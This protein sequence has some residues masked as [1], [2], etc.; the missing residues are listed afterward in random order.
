MVAI[1]RAASPIWKL[2]LIMSTTLGAILFV[3][4]IALAVLGKTAQTSFMLFGNQFSST[5]VGVS[6][7]FLGAVFV[8]LV[9]RRVLGGLDRV[10]S[11]DDM[12]E[13]P[14]QSPRRNRVRR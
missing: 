2:S 8:T 12:S 6:L 11:G 4:G 3:G 7:A 13:S 10:A 9:F 1:I 5:S 14:R